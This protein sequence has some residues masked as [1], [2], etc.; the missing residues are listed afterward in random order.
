MISVPDL[1][2][3]HSS[4]HCHFY[5]DIG[6]WCPLSRTAHACHFSGTCTFTVLQN[7]I[8]FCD[9][10]WYESNQSS[11]LNYPEQEKNPKF[12]NDWAQQT[13]K[14]SLEQDFSNK[15]A[16]NL[17]LFLGDGKPLIVHFVCCKKLQ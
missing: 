7:L 13:L 17:I 12:W 3:I 4:S 8:C 5:R 11:S 10:V 2:R 6:P 16:K 9:L 14:D 15:K 1:Y